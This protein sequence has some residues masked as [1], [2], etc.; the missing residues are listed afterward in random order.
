M[1]N[2]SF[3][4]ELSK[5]YD[6]RP[7]ILIENI[8]MWLK[9]NIKENNCNH[10]CMSMNEM[11]D[12]SKMFSVRQ[13]RYI[14]DKLIKKGVLGIGMCKNTRTY[15]IKD[16]Y[17]IELYDINY[18][19]NNKD[20]KNN[21][22][23]CKKKPEQTIDK[24]GTDKNGTD[25]PIDKNGQCQKCQI[26]SNTD[27]KCNKKL[28]TKM[29]Y[30]IHDIYNNNIYNNKSYIMKDK[31]KPK[32]KFIKTQLTKNDNDFICEIIKTFKEKYNAVLIKGCIEV[33]FRKKGKK[34]K[35]LLLHYVNNFKNHLESVRY[36][37]YDIGRFFYSTVLKEIVTP[38]Q[39]VPQQKSQVQYV[40]KP[41]QSTNYEQRKYD[42][43]FF[44]GLYANVE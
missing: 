9:E 43:S 17:I 1:F 12:L 10:I 41:I 21:P 40:Q 14:L 18:L 8:A 25:K 38:V 39:Y 24:N 34:A 35:E 29:A 30:D 15:T 44:E 20:N 2:Y 23:N 28:L 33:L 6:I 26:A 31:S 7:A 22:D 19:D 13:I 36:V 3:N 27:K 42:D 32:K 4:L 16:K 5:R 37:I 11:S